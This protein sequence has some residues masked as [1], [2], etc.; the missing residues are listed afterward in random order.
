MVVEEEER[1]SSWAMMSKESIFCSMSGSRAV[2]AG[3]TGGGSEAAARISDVVKSRRN[4]IRLMN[5]GSE[6]SQGNKAGVW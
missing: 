5:P 6:A 4:R 3:G 2:G 1:T